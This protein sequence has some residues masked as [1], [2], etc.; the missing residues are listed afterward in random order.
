MQR[1]LLTIRFTPMSVPQTA[2]HQTVDRLVDEK[3]K[4]TK[5]EEIKI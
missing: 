2:C 5:K 4:K 3:R 1:N